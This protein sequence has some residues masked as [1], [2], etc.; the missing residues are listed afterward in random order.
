LPLAIPENV[1]AAFQCDNKGRV[2]WFNITPLYP[3]N[4]YPPG[5]AIGL[6]AQHLSKQELILRFV[7]ADS[8]NLKFKFLKHYNRNLFNNQ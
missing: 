4:S 1:A 2:M 6:S 3:V 8:E 7:V 5:V